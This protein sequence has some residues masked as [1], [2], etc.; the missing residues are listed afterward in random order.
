MDGENE[1]KCSG[2]NKG[3]KNHWTQKNVD[4]ACKKINN[5]IYGRNRQAP[6]HIKLDDL[7]VYINGQ[8][9]YRKLYPPKGKISKLLLL[10]D[11]LL[12]RKNRLFI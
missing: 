4:T 9:Q 8:F 1:V 3:K 11:F 5:E 10:K 6:L 7:A 12:Y 2:K